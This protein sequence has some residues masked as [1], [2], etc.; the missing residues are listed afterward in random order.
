MHLPPRSQH[1]APC[2]QGTVMTSNQGQSVSSYG[3]GNVQHR[4]GNMQFKPKPPSHQQ[5]VVPARQTETVMSTNQGPSASGSS[6]GQRSVHHSQGHMQFK[7]HPH[8]QLM[9]SG[10]QETFVATNQG[11]SGAAF[12]RGNAQHGQLNMQSKPQPLSHQQLTMQQSLGRQTPSSSGGRPGGVPF[13]GPRFPSEPQKQTPQ[14]KMKLSSQHGQ[15]KKVKTDFH[16]TESA[17]SQQQVHICI[18]YCIEHIICIYL[19]LHCE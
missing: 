17:Q 2:R 12:G 5:N 13:S 4:Q 11:Q 14:W 9:F 15:A 7:P 10:R 18:S 3:Q 1:N 8:Q 16:V 19:C 6:F